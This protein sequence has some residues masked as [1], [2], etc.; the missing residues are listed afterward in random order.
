ME[1]NITFISCVNIDESLLTKEYI[2]KVLEELMN[3]TS[4]KLVDG[5]ISYNINKNYFISI[6]ITENG[7]IVMD[8]ERE[9]RKVKI[10]FDY[11]YN[12]DY[13]NII[14]YL[15]KEFRLSLNSIRLFRMSESD[16]EITECED[17]NCTRKASKIWEG[18]KL[19]RDHYEKYKDTDPNNELD[20]HNY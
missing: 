12:I 5:P 8:T 7:K 2:N 20:E 10:I 1:N 19:C 18:R 16:E 9:N 15:I 14:N 6:I 4:S 17:Y 11:K 13:E 3:I